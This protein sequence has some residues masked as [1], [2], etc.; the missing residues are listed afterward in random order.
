MHGKF[1]GSDEIR[2]TRRVIEM[3]NHMQRRRE[4]RAASIAAIVVAGLMTGS[5]GHAADLN[6]DGVIDGTDQAI[7]LGSWGPCKGCPSDL[8]GD[9]V[10]D[11]VDL[12]IWM[13]PPADSTGGGDTVDDGGLYGPGDGDDSLPPDGDGDGG[14]GSSGSGG[15]DPMGDG[16]EVHA[17]PLPAPAWMT[18]GG[19]LGAAYVRRR[20][21]GR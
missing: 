3:K 16:G 7:L 19:L 12:A 11:G 15:G 20:M 21:L 9:G 10:V 4:L 13:S 8:N 17:I 6:G 18:L 5:D 14:S 1:E 2:R